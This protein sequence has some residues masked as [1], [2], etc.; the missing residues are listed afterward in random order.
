[1]RYMSFT[2]YKKYFNNLLKPINFSLPITFAQII[3]LILQLIISSVTKYFLLLNN[4]ENM[5]TNLSDQITHEISL[6][7]NYWD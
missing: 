2:S 4:T 1:M 5:L 6:K 3:F 7:G